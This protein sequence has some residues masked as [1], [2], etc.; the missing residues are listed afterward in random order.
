M[1]AAFFTLLP[2]IILGESTSESDLV[3][4]CPKVTCSEPLGDNVCFMHSGT[5]PVEW[6]KLQQC[7][8]G[9]LCDYTQDLAWYDT[10]QQSIVGSSSPYKSPT[11]RKQT[12]A[13]CE[14]LTAYRQNLLPGRDCSSNYECQ[15]FNCLDS[16]CKG[17]VSG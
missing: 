17:K 2:L 13:K 5:N 8:R 7:P 16:R 1:K 11:W 4:I 15:S 3:T 6:I 10:L 9:Y 14:P 12:I